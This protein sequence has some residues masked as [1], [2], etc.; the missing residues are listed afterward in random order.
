QY[1]DYTLWQHTVLGDESDPASTAARQ[2]AFWHDALAGA[3]ELLE[4]PWDRPRPVQQSGRGARVAFEIDADTHRGMLAL[5]REHDASLFMVVHAALAVLLARLSTSDDIVVG[6][7][8]AGRGDRALDD[9]VG[10]FVNTVVLRARVDERERFDSLLRR[11]R[12][13]DLAAFGQADV[14]FER[15]VEALDPPRS[16]SYPPL[17]QVLLEFQDIE[18][19]EIALPGA[20]ARVLDLDP[21][22]SPFDLQLSIAERP[23]G[24]SGVRAAFTYATDLFDAD[25]VASF[26]DRFVRILD[27]VTADASVTV[28]DVEIVTPRELATLAPARG[29]PAVSPQLWPELLSSVAAIVPEAVALSF[30][31]RTVTYGELD[32][33][34]NRLARVLTSHGVGPESFVALGISRSIESVAAVW[35]VTKSG[36]AFVPVDP[37]YPP[38]RIA[39]MLDDCRATLGL[40]TTAHRDVWPADA[41]SWLL[42][43]DPGLRRR[44]DDVSPA[45]VTD[46]DRRTPLRYDHPAYLIYTSGSTGRPKGVVVTHRGLT[47]L[48]AE[49]REHFSITHRARVSHLASPSF[50]ASLFELT[51]AFCAGAT[52]VIVPPS[53]YGGE[54]LA[55]ILREERITHAFVTPTALA[56]L[57]PAGLDELRVLVVAGEACPPELV[58]RWAPGRH[59]YNGYGPSEATIETSVSPDMRPDT[60]VTVGGPAIGFHEVVLDERLRPVPIG[61][62]GELYIAGAG[63]ARGYHRRPELTASRFVADPFG[64]PGERMYRTGDVV[65]WRTDGT[66][67]Y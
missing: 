52:L 55:R 7:P 16:T 42:L 11:V 23:G 17:F 63:L 37:G 31:G 13:A 27:A 51:K 28:G 6:T 21:G 19:P 53:V 67:E 30:E 1:A 50:D 34:S 61:V 62:A 44:L 38:E 12:S 40:T 14:P 41:V 26:A 59:M 66:V 39:Y 8:V 2:L 3:P 57:D 43:D 48:N 24:G 36:A 49:V 45:P 15:L 58:D 56:S 22:L 32:A 9:L 33:W 18:R 54:E 65:R 20:T 10:M 47:N 5:A 35:A 29:R 46:D 60:T 4:L 64:A 25:T